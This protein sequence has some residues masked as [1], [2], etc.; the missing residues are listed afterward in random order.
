MGITDG[1]ILSDK[2]ISVDFIHTYDDQYI[3]NGKTES[4]WTADP[5]YH[6]GKYKIY[7]TNKTSHPIYIDLSKSFR[8][9]PGGQTEPFYNN[10]SITNTSGQQSGGTLNLGAVTNS[11]GIGGPIGK[12]AQ[13]IGIE[14]SS[15][16]TTSVTATENNIVIIPPDGKIL[17]PP[18]K[19]VLTEGGVL[20]EFENINPHGVQERVYQKVTVDNSGKIEKNRYVAFPCDEISKGMSYYITYSTTPDFTTYTSLSFGFYVRGVFGSEGHYD[21]FTS[22]DGKVIIGTGI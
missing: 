15:I 19:R 9:W 11:I 17:M 18:R 8:K 2:N 16:N 22:N 20:I 3:K 5:K 4:W 13:G 14:K 6:G 12:L 7:I 1:S 10:I 21:E